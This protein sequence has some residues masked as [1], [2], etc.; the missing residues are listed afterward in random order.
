LKNNIPFD[1]IT[2]YGDGILEQIY[3]TELGYV[4]GRVYYPQK[5]VWINY[6]LSNVWDLTK[7]SNIDIKIENFHKKEEEILELS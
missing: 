7:K 4:M 2:E 6:I 5:G 1:V 3:T